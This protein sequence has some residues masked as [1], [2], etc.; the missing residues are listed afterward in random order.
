MLESKQAFTLGD[1]FP[2]PTHPRNGSLLQIRVGE[3]ERLDVRVPAAK[4]PSK[5][6]YHIV[7]LHKID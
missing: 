6:E 7:S 5:Y 2:I 4:V 1:F 3:S